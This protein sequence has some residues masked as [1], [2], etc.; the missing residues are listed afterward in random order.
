MKEQKQRAE[1]TVSAM[2]DEMSKLDAKRK[3]LLHENTAIIDKL[4]A[5]KEELIALGREKESGKKKML[6]MEDEEEEK[7]MKEERD[8]M[9]ELLDLQSREIDTLMTEIN[10]FRRKGGHI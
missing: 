8:K 1:E 5:Q 4:H 3:D 9:K 2:S 6:N 10:L 7:K